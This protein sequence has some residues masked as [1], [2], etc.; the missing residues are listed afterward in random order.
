M[1][2]NP[3]V[4]TLSYILSKHK[5]YSQEYQFQISTA[6]SE[7]DVIYRITHIMKWLFIAT[8]NSLGRNRTSLD[9]VFKQSC[10]KPCSHNIVIF[11]SI[12]WCVLDGAEVNRQ[13]IKIHFKDEEEEVRKS[14]VT[15][16]LYTG[17]PMVF[18]MDP[19]VLILYVYIM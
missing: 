8:C 14:F 17:E 16:N 15:P 19:K 9:I 4:G 12:Y 6:A 13:F 2:F 5:S 1:D 18:F 11:Y 7:S 10:T 3:T